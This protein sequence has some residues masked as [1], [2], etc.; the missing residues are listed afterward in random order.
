MQKHPSSSA[1]SDEN[2]MQRLLA[3]EEAAF[4]ELARRFEARL[5]YFAWRHLRDE[6]AAKD[7]AQETLLRLWRHRAEF[8]SGSRLSTWVFAINLNLCRD[9]LRKNG[10]L[11]PIDRPEVALAA[12]MSE[13]RKGK[14]TALDAAEKREMLGLL[15]QALDSLPGLQAELLRLR[16]EEGLSF[17]EAGGRLGLK[18]AAARAAASRAYKKLKLWMQ[19]RTKDR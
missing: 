3:G 14:P 12:E 1:E 8:R 5:Y 17:E 15:G 6:E 18:P 13:Q 9:Y 7:M 4:E 11:S 10:R 2:L 16:N 19:E